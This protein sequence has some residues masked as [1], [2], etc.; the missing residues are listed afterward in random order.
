MHRIYITLIISLTVLFGVHVRAQN[1]S[2]SDL[3]K[4][5]E[6]SRKLYEVPGMSVTIVQEGRTLL[7]KGY[8]HLGVNQAQKV[9]EE[10]LFVMASTTKA[11]TAAAMAILVDEG[12]VK[13]SDKVT[14][15]LPT[16]KLSEPYVTN[17]ITIKDLFTHNSG[18]SGTDL[19]WTMWDYS[20]EE[21]IERIAEAPLR[22]SLRSGYR[23]QNVMYMTAGL[24]IEK[25]SGQNWEAFI[26][27]KIFDP[28]GMT[29]TYGLRS[30]AYMD[31]NRV[32][33][34]ATVDGDVI[35]IIDSAADSINAAGSA[36][37]CSKDIARWIQ[38]MADSAQING[39]RLISE[40]GYRM[41]TSPHIIIPEA[42][43][44]SSQVY[45][46]PH[47]RAYGLGWYMHDYQ[48]EKVLF[49]TG[50]LNGAV[51]IAG[52]LPEHNIGV[53]ITANLGGAEVRHALMYKIF[54]DLLGLESRDWSR[55]IKQLYE[56][57]RTGSIVRRA[58]RLGNREKEAPPTHALEVFT[59]IYKNK[60]LGQLTIALHEDGLRITTRSDRHI[61]LSHWH[62]NSFMGIV[63][64]YKEFEKGSLFDFDINAYGQPSLDL[65]GYEFEKVND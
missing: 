23:Y 2:I 62:Y 38:F 32:R 20:P 46:K 12:K 47:F 35:E 7:S 43:F 34:H 55:D 49:H 1:E 18:L 45:T 33:P 10:T 50:S 39:R 15:Y 28:L 58:L 64:E 57:I 60:F 29:R 51:A 6:E 26:E 25:I 24:V 36:W 8:G 16:F 65:Y 5:I 19:L 31:T 59:G 54:D 22:Y 53:Y 11:F 13:W 61:I 37:T 17:E 27:Q 48:G 40:E 42:Q 52:L 30:Q 9:D 63:E 3:D 4:Y 44:Y 41:I 56:N 14:K 21:M